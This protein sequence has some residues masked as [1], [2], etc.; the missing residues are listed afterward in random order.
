MIEAKGS[1]GTWSMLRIGGVSQNDLGYDMSVAYLGK[2]HKKGMGL[3]EARWY[4]P[5]GVP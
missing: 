2:T 4:A 5:S 1:D 3:Y